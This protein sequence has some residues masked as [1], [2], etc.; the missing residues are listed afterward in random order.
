VHVNVARVST[1]GEE[2][3]KKTSLLSETTE[4]KMGEMK[5]KVR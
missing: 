2:A 4:E 5:Q 3:E 1:S